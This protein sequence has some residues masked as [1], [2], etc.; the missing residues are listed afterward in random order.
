LLLIV[1]LLLAACG[2]GATDKEPAAIDT[3]DR[4]TV[5]ARTATSDSPEPTQAPPTEVPATETEPAVASLRPESEE[6]PPPTGTVRAANQ[7]EFGRTDFLPD[8][9]SDGQ[10]AWPF[11]PLDDPEFMTADEATYLASN[12]LVLGLSINGE[13]KAYPTNL[14]WFHHVANDTVGGEPVAVTY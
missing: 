10:G 13:H 14:M 7:N 1:M 5:A 8:Y 2:G 9:V 12:D 4:P 3:H 11:V 6:T